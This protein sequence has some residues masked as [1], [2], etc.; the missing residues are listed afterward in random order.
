MLG[1]FWRAECTLEEYL[2]LDDDVTVNWSVVGVVAGVEEK[3]A[4]ADLKYP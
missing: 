3:D 1:Y 2:E 4:F